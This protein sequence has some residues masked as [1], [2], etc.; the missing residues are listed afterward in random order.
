MKKK[1]WLGIAMTAV[2]AIG[3]LAACSNDE[4]T[5]GSSSGKGDSSTITFW[6][7]F[8]GPD[9]PRMKSIVEDYNKSQSEYKVDFQIVP[10]SD[11]Y[12]TVD[13]SFSGQK[14]GP[15]VM[16]MHRDQLPT[17]VEKKL[18]KDVTETAEKAGVKE[19]NYAETAWE[20]G[21]ID[22]KQYGIPLDIHPL[23]FYYNKD[24]FK[25]AGLDPEKPPTNREEFLDAAKKLTDSSKNQYG[26]VVP[27]LWPN[28]F[29]YP[30]VLFQNG[31]EL[32]KDGK[33]NYNSPEGVEALTFL[34]D[35]V[36]KEKVS[37][38]NVQQDGEVTLFLQGKNAMHLNGPWMMEQW[39]KAKLNY[40]VAPVPQLGTKQQAVY[41]NAHNFVIPA[42][43][44]DEKKLDATTD[45]L[46]YVAE[47]TM[48]W[49]KSGQAPASK[50]VYESAE[51]QKMKQQPQ[52][53]K[54]FEYA[55]FAPT[56]SNWGQISEPLWQEV[57]LALLGKK[58]PQKALD[59]ATKKAE[60][61]ANK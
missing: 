12:K 3:S 11:Y 33:P 5:T 46:K 14:N 1:K 10:Q 57:N 60:Q 23:V 20:G 55:K 13:L 17:Y 61:L 21:Q 58:D 24:L 19:E 26:F 59:D 34:S 44:K 30:T 36:K 53:A 56:V 6:A 42:S 37:P 2:L 16:I 32:L 39:D 47:N 50:A 25:Q 40:G 48:E 28:Q 41:A 31:G 51:F 38:A 8:S 52:V 4:K 22:G 43:V 49:A 29:I 45:F 54:Q 35:L 15:D 27:T 9:G 18:V 7:P